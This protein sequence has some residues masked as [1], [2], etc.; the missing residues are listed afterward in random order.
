MQTTAK[1]VQV[2]IDAFRAAGKDY[3]IAMVACPECGS[4]SAFAEITPASIDKAVNLMEVA[5]HKKAVRGQ[6][7]AHLLAHA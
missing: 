3:N 4:E 5:S 6:L 2:Q 7:A 1:S